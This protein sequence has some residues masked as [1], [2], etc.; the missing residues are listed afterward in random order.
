MRLCLA[1]SAWGILTG[2]LIFFP[3]LAFIDT[4][5]EDRGYKEEPGKLQ[6]SPSMP[7]LSCIIGLSLKTSFND[8]LFDCSV[9]EPA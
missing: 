9:L 8:L 2:C 6:P 5:L 1:W 4:P 3:G 7:V